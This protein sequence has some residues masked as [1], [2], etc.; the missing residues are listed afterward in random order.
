MD[1]PDD[2]FLRIR[3]WVS[4]H[5]QGGCK[6]LSLGDKCPCPLCDIDRLRLAI[7]AYEEERE[8]AANAVQHGGDHYIK[9]GDVQPWDVWS[10]WQLDP[11]QASVVK[12]IVRWKDKNGLLDLDKVEH[13]LAKYREEIAKGR[14]APKP[15]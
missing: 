11:F 1:T 4:D 9:Y 3:E 7:G 8:S 6:V 2:I 12:Y 14:Y 15:K 13:Y 5:L 10:L